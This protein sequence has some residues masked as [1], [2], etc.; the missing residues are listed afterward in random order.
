MQ[1]N[2]GTPGIV[3]SPPRNGR[4]HYRS[5]KSMAPDC[6]NDQNR[7]LAEQLCSR[8]HH[9][10]NKQS[11]RRSRQKNPRL[12]A[13]A[14]PMS[15]APNKL[16]QIRNGDVER[17]THISEA[18]SDVETSLALAFTKR[19]RNKLPLSTLLCSP[20][21]VESRITHAGHARLQF[22]R[23]S[24]SPSSSSRPS[25]PITCYPCKTN[26]SRSMDAGQRKIC[27]FM[28]AIP[29]KTGFRNQQRSPQLSYSRKRLCTLDEATWVILGRYPC[30]GKIF[31]EMADES[32]ALPKRG[33][34]GLCI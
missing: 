17:K 14:N 6:A 22:S 18:Y 31:E 11:R 12:L 30:V 13:D 15:H 19:R 23:I 32:R 4:H 27:V 21:V 1:A 34:S 25:V 8:L 10:Q 29:R 28:P 16:A 5:R 3:S 24:E 9:D 33:K 7:S 20:E 26:V 2:H